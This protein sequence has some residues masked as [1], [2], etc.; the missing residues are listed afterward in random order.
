LFWGAVSF[1]GTTSTAAT[2]TSLEGSE[3]SSASKKTNIQQYYGIENDTFDVYV[4]NPKQEDLKFLLKAHLNGLDVWPWIWTQPND[5][6]GPHHVFVGSIG[7]KEIQLMKSLK[8]EQPNVNLLVIT[9]TTT[10]T[11]TIGLQR[12]YELECGIVLDT[13]VELSDLQNK[14]I[15]LEDERVICFTKLYVS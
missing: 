12:L 2:T 10:A 14:I 7:E 9:D 4:D 11:E 6:N 13:H 15:M 3:P 1:V 8:K 5:D